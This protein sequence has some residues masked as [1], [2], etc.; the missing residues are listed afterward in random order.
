MVF[1][2]DVSFNLLESWILRCV[3]VQP[4]FQDKVSQIHVAEGG[5]FPSYMLQIVT[6][7]DIGIWTFRDCEGHRVEL[8]IDIVQ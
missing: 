5:I 4:A 7:F 3:R 1:R 8:T 6:Y 2:R